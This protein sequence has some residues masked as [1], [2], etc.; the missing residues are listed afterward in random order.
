[1]LGTWVALSNVSWLAAQC[2]GSEGCMQFGPQGGHALWEVI[3]SDQTELFCA[4]R[5]LQ[6]LKWGQG[7]LSSSTW[8][9]RDSFI[10]EDKSG[11]CFERYVGAS[12]MN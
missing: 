1:M 9:N 4:L 5:T 11:L 6:A 12:Q 7:R 3:A 10:Q 8:G 2:Q